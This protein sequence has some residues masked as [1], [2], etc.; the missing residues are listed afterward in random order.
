[1]EKILMHHIRTGIA[2]L[3]TGL[4]AATGW[5]VP[6]SMRLE[7]WKFMKA[8][9]AVDAS[10]SEWETVTVP[11]TW[12]AEDGQGDTYYRGPGWYQTTLQ[13]EQISSADR[14]FVRFQA[15]GTVA[16]VVVDGETVAHHV[17]GYTAFSA[18]LT[19]FVKDGKT[20]D[21]RVRANNEYLDTVAPLSGDFTIW[22]GM[23]RP[24]E[25]ILKNEV[26]ISPIDH[27]SPGVYLFQENV[28]DVK[29]DLR[30]CVLVDNGSEEDKEIRVVLSLTDDQGNTVAEQEVAEPVDAGEIDEVEQVLTL[31]EPHLWNGTA[32]P[33]LYTLKVE[34][35]D[36]SEKVDQYT[37]KTGFRTFRIDPETGF[38][39][40]GKPYPLHGVNLHYDRKSVGPALT[41]EHV[42]EDYELVMEIGANTVRL[43]HYPHAEISYERCDELGLL[44]W[45]EI[46]VVNSVKIRPGFTEST[47]G[48]LRDMI[49]QL[50]NHPS[51][52]CW[53]ISNEILHRPGDSPYE[54]LEQLH[55]LAKYLDPTRHTTMA[56]NKPREDRLNRV[57]DILAFNTY[58]GWYGKN[59]ESMSPTIDK[60]NE[61]GGLRGVGV[62]EYGAGGA[63]EHQSQKLE[64]VAH[65]G[66]WHP[67]QWQAYLHERQYNGILQHPECW[68]SYVW[69]MFDFTSAGRTEGAHNGM[70]DKGLVT[71]DHITRKD[72]FYFY[73]ANWSDSPVLHLT[74]K[75]HL[76]RH[77]METPVKVYS[78]CDEIELSINDKTIGT[79]KPNDLNIAL[80][81]SIQLVKGENKIVVKASA[82]GAELIDQV[83]WTADPSAL[84]P[85]EDHARSVET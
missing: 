25:L 19:P 63:I 76:V 47:C 59:P 31:A 77:A 9:A 80:W 3:L 72:A 84:P 60:F 23:H 75:R 48:Q 83:I 58:P 4:C 42:N 13:P 26:C 65:R 57:T 78:N 29:A 50:G 46:P 14:V 62:S 52:F 51:I 33:Y 67:E 34:L 66:N 41:E 56:S 18:E 37:K 71:H 17:G 39:L 16:D 81:E 8:D 54:L 36:R 6:E 45:A 21:L 28:S 35:Y 11:H 55:V 10:V 85:E 79:L 49:K 1:M 20:H 22:G 61:S 27:A 43:A 38:Y 30:V 2:V 53:S 69:N 64:R 15:V 82:D 5:S 70:N 24:A 68:G 7:S 73:K 44:V 40:N 74:S 12:N 32:D